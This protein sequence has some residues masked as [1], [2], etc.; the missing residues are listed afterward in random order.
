MFCPSVAEKCWKTYTNWR[1]L[2]Q[3]VKKEIRTQNQSR[4]GFGR[5][6]QKLEALPL[7]ALS[8]S[9]GA[10]KAASATHP[11][12]CCCHAC[13]GTAVLCHPV[14][15]WG[16]IWNSG[17]STE[18][19]RS[20]LQAA[21]LTG[22]ASTLTVFNESTKSGFA[23]E[24]GTKSRKYPGHNFCDGYREGTKQPFLAWPLWADHTRA[25]KQAS[26][27]DA[28]IPAS[29]L[30]A[31]A[32]CS[33]ATATAGLLPA[34][35]EDPSPFQGPPLPLLRLAALQP[36]STASSQAA[37][38]APA[39]LQFPIDWGPFC[40]EVVGNWSVGAA[41]S[42]RPNFSKEMQPRQESLTLEI[43]WVSYATC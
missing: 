33:S 20:L 11:T 23:R 24:A 28:S 1:L 41:T 29:C 36:S 3:R 26:Y 8:I 25:I 40:L 35:R 4:V 32:L 38:S 42:S 2:A 22:F 17:A 27:W 16:D 10:Q 14:L 21:A 37:A 9:H 6:P 31:R 7:Q 43:G 39:L 18:R 34:C 5:G 30:R 19:S 12:R 15:I 13:C